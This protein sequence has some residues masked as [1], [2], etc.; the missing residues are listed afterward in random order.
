[1]SLLFLLYLSFASEL[2]MQKRD[3]FVIT[4]LD[5]IMQL[6][7][8]HKSIHSDTIFGSILQYYSFHNTWKCIYMVNCVTI[9]SAP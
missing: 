4:G 1:M 9:L 7:R 6:Y 3:C 5:Q 8:Y 2:K